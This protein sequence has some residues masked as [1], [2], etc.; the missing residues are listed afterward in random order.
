[1][2]VSEFEACTPEPLNSNSFNPAVVLPYGLEVAHIRSALE[3]F[4]DFLGFMNLQLR[5]RQ[6]PRLETFIMP[7]NFSSLVGEFMNASIPKYCPGLTKNRY[8]NGHPDLVPTGMFPGNAV[9]YA[10]EGIEVKASRKKSGWQGHNPEAIWL[11]VFSF[12]ANSASDATKNRPVRRFRFAGVYA[13][14]LE[15]DDWTFEG[16]SETSR[17]TITATV[18]PFGMQ[19]LRAN[20][21]YKVSQQTRIDLPISV[22]E[23]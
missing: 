1:M 5:S 17:R 13:A 15:V 4:V 7:A 8:H 22:E 14:K 23:T 6:I 21:V 11:M 3:E 2:I 10:H 19:K 16:R 18:N 20:W 12:E 9:Q